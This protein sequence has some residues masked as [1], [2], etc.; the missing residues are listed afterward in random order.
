[1]SCRSILKTGKPC[2]NSTAPGHDYCRLHHKQIVRTHKTYKKCERSA[3][4]LP[5]TIEGYCAKH[6]RTQQALSLRKKQEA[7][8]NKPDTGHRTYEEK[9]KL[10]LMTYEEK[11]K[12][13]FSKPLAETAVEEDTEEDAEEYTTD[14]LPAP[15]PSHQ[16]SEDDSDAYLNAAIEAN[17]AIAVK[18]LDAMRPILSYIHTLFDVK[19]LYEK[20]VTSQEAF[21][22]YTLANILSNTIVDCMVIREV[23]Q[24]PIARYV[25][26]F[27]VIALFEESKTLVDI[28]VRNELSPVAREAVETGYRHLHP[29]LKPVIDRINSV[30]IPLGYIC[31][32]EEKRFYAEPYH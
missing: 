18:R 31:Y 27:D 11:L 4:A 22:Q 17:R 21:V 23:T 30:P 15:I 7:L 10:D 14:V 3:A 19:T 20:W 6:A 32:D 26:I 25:G 16:S 12:I 2:N 28:F 9:L 8:V 13:L 29:L 5:P 24:K 1:M